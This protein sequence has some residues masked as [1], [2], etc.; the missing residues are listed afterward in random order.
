[1]RLHLREVVVELRLR[2]VPHLLPEVEDAEGPADVRRRIAAE[3]RV[4]EEREASLCLVEGRHVWRGLLSV[5][6]SLAF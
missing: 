4:E 5:R 2:L 6:L 1:M 3:S